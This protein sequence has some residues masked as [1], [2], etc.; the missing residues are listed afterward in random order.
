MLQWLK[1]KIKKWLEEDASYIVSSLDLEILENGK[2]VKTTAL[3]ASGLYIVCRKAMGCEVLI[4]SSQARDSELYW[5][6]WTQLTGCKK[7]TDEYGNE[8]KLRN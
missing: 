3:R 2:I 7:L 8:L 1:K 4:N 5:K 6:L